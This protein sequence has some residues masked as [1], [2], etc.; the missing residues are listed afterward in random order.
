MK[1]SG[2]TVPWLRIGAESVAIVAS[3]LL[4][5]SIDTWWN[6]RQNAA[7]ETAILRVLYSELEETKR[8]A[9]DNRIYVAALND[10]YRQFLEASVGPDAALTDSEIDK[11]LADIHWKIDPSFLAVPSLRA[12]MSSGDLEYIANGDLRRKLGV[13]LLNFDGLKYEIE[14][15]ARYFDD[16]I[17]TYTQQHISMVQFYNVESHQPGFPER[18]WEADPLPLSSVT[19]HRDATRSME[20]QNLLLQRT[21]LLTNVLSWAESD[22]EDVIQDAVDLI[23]QELSE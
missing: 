9:V 3:I 20:F 21:T 18:M 23:E 5:F 17:I 19:S 8:F 1:I 11:F 12:V 13:L 15:D 6:S 7:E 2:A 10:A 4:A 14:R 16:K 22:I